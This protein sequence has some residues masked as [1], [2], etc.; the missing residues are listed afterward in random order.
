M[1]RTMTAAAD[2]IGTAPID[3]LIA[4]GRRQQNI[5]GGRAVQRRPDARQRIRVV[6]ALEATVER[7]RRRAHQAAPSTLHSTPAVV[8][9]L[10]AR[11]EPQLAPLAAD[12]GLRRADPPA[13]DMTRST[14]SRSADR[15]DARGGR[16]RRDDPRRARRSSPS[17]A[18]DSPR[19]R[20]RPS[21]TRSGWRC[22]NAA[23][24]PVELDPR[25]DGR[26][27]MVRGDDHRVLRRGT[28]PDRRRRASDARADG[29][30]PRARSPAS[31]GRCDATR[32]R[33]PGARTAGSRTGRARRD[34]RRRSRCAGRGRPASRAA[35]GSR[36]AD[37][38]TGRRRTAR[39]DPSIVRR[40]RVEVAIRAS[41]VS[42]ETSC[43]CRPR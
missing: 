36:S 20:R 30:R 6:V 14:P 12:H 1:Q 39:A 26:L 27:R 3:E 37:S 33:C 35:R 22:G 19:A 8:D 38:R 42:L 16:A 18:R 7:P 28:R 9:H 25:L 5:A 15:I 13:S 21:G 34:T 43:W 32:R 41:A 11:R 2:V 23:R 4:R 40:N 17:A 29:R 10:T 31:A 24:A